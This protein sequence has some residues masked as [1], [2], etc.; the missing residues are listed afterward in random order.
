MNRLASMAFALLALFLLLVAPSRPASVREAASAPNVRAA[1]SHRA[2]ERASS[3]ARQEP[4]AAGERAATS[5]A[6]LFEALARPSPSSVRGVADRGELASAR[7]ITR[8]PPRA[9]F[10]SRGGARP[11]L[12]ASTGTVASLRC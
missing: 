8:S 3:D 6:T 7:R 11:S 10:A 1:S 2:T 5:A 4:L 9:P 12:I